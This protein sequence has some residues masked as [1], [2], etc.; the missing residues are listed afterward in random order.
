MKK[1]LKKWSVWACG[2]FAALGF[3]G[4]AATTLAQ[5][6]ATS[7][8]ASA[9]AS[10]SID[11]LAIAKDT[12]S[13][14][15]YAYPT[16]EEQRPTVK[17]WDDAFTFVAGT[18]G[19]FLYNG[20]PYSGWELKQPGDF[21]IGLGR[22]AVSG[23]V[24]IMDGTFYN[25]DKDVNIVFN[26]NAFLYNGTDWETCQAVA[27]G[28]MSADSEKSDG[29]TLT[30]TGD[31]TSMSG[32]T[33][34]PVNEFV[35]VNGENATARISSRKT[36]ANGIVFEA[37][38][39]DAIA[40]VVNVYGLYKDESGVYY[41]IT[42]SYFMWTGAKWNTLNNYDAV[43]DKVSIISADMFV[44][45]AT[46]F[47][48]QTKYN[49]GFE[50]W[51]NKMSI[52]NGHGLKLNGK[53]LQYGALKVY[54]DKVHVNLGTT[55]KVNDVL[56]INGLF[57][58]SSGYQ[59]L[60]APTQALKW[61]GSH[62]ENLDYTTYDFDALT[63]HSNS[64]AG[65]DDVKASGIYMARKDG[66]WIPVNDW[67][68]AFTYENGVNIKKNG[69][70]IS[71]MLKS[72]DGLLY[73]D[74]ADV[75]EGDV[76]SIGGTFTCASHDV[77]YAIKES[78]FKW[79]GTAWEDSSAYT[80][81]TIDTISVNPSD[82]TEN[83][84]FVD[85]G[86]YVGLST[87]DY[88][89]TLEG[90][91]G[92]TYNGIVTNDKIVMKPLGEKLYIDVHTMNVK[93]GDI[94]TVEGTYMCTVNGITSEVYFSSMQTLKF[95]DGA[96]VRCDEATYLIGKMELHSDS[97]NGGPGT[98][99]DHLYLQRAD[100]EAM[101]LQDGEWEYVFTFEGGNGL[102][103]NGQPSSV[104]EMKSPGRLWFSFAG[105]EAGGTV[106]ISGSFV[107]ATANVRYII[108]ENT[109]TW[110]GSVWE[111][112]TTYQTGRLISTSDSNA[113]QIYLEKEN[114]EPFEVTEGTWTEKLTFLVGSGVGVTL[115]DTQ[116]A[117]DDMKIPNAFF[118]GLGKTAVKGDVLKIGGIFYNANLHVKYD[119]EE[120][121]FVWNGTAWI[122]DYSNSEI[123]EFDT[124]SIS[125]LGWGLKKELEG[126]QDYSELSYTESAENTTGSVAFRFGYNSANVGAGCIDIRLRGS[127]WEG[128]QFRILE[129]RVELVNSIQTAL[130]NNTDHV[131][132]IGAIDTAD[133][134]QIWVYIKVDGVLMASEMIANNEFHTS[135]VSIYASGIAA[136]TF[137]D[138]DHVEVT[139]QYTNGEEAIAYA[140]KG[141]EYKL[142]VDPTANET[143]VGWASNNALY[144]AGEVI[145]VGE[146]NVTYI[147]ISL[148]FQLKDGAAIRL[149]SS[150]DDS[151]IRFTPMMKT[152]D[153]EA[154]QSY[155][156]ELAFGT[157]IMPFDYLG[158]GQAPNLTDFVAGSTVLQIP[159][160]GYTEQDKNNSAYTAYYGAMKKLYTQNYG[161]NFAGR[162]YMIITYANGATKTIYTPFDTEK[163]VRSVKFVATK[164][165]EDTT[166][167]EKFGTLK[168]AVVDAYAASADYTPNNVNAA[169]T[170]A[171]VQESYAAAYV[172]ANKEYQL[173]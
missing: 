131:I 5:P 151:G 31:A 110:S 160:G 98:R 68:T 88:T 32:K 62:W 50:D 47:Y 140:E 29:N 134:S 109:F 2:L 12:T 24:L 132:E 44:E 37:T 69:A 59:V 100:G 76:I 39:E 92:F 97:T 18:G 48:V 130:S 166:E 123:A 60:F 91:K 133:N 128:M 111:S 167:Y 108:E 67:S 34:T 95:A 15:I 40:D 54:L 74:V 57:E 19:G 16:V 8:T 83:G 156:K 75:K 3:V 30:L 170:V 120:S 96:W 35:F 168:K 26:N 58:H 36:T 13:S 41:A 94:L 10:F 129:N 87:W 38:M 11:E 172:Y 103:I 150:A 46:S 52:L 164:L 173:A 77:R 148:D 119:V 112:F 116:L 142:V 27:F 106:T 163:N 6:I 138:P 127:A 1:M 7:V 55:A 66:G 162:G 80:M 45:N 122:S 42:D 81:T 139:Y 152:S 84:F 65:G 171:S 33:L 136:T 73:M 17:S 144:Q 25:A 23:D 107:S 145:I 21:Y 64:Q 161:R 159:N 49:A 169:S 101:P 82:N 137:T 149:S 154:L 141:A 113:G 147:A 117:M 71:C 118:V 63:V 61:N 86:G 105:V 126:T 155:A 70:A 115:N 79:N 56:T 20:E 85:I 153:Y 146:S 72:A 9:A 53:P 89:F 51:D 78:F 93:N 143:F 43:I 22:T 28:R 165:Q 102:I 135:H 125:D 104:L 90:G 158:A 4:G 14:A 99:N 114:G 124:I 121:A 157:L